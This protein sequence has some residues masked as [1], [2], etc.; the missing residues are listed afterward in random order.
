MW[1]VSLVCCMLISFLCSGAGT[2]PH[3]PSHPTQFN[4]L[5]CWL[6]CFWIWVVCSCPH[7]ALCFCHSLPLH[8]FPV[9]V[10]ILIGGLKV[11]TSVTYE[12]TFEV[13]QLQKQL[14]VAPAHIC[15]CICLAISHDHNKIRIGN[16]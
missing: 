6:F 2:V 12:N 7:S 3:D 5:S 1:L 9:K 10:Y 15:V 4:I 8:Y 13:L 14:A 11:G 16:S